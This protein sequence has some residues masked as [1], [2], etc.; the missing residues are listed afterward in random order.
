MKGIAWKLVLTIILVLIALYYLYPTIR[1]ATLPEKVRKENPALVDSLQLKGLRL[2][3]DL[4]GGTHLVY[5]VD[6]TKLPPDMAEIPIDE[7]LEVIR[8]RVDQFGVAEPVIQKAGETRIIVELPGIQDIERAKQLIQETALLEFRLM[9]DANDVKRFVD[10]MDRLLEEH[11]EY[12]EMAKAGKI[13]EKAEAETTEI[14]ET[15]KAVAESLLAKAEKGTTEVAAHIESTKTAKKETTVITGK[16]I[17]GKEAEKAEEKPTPAPEEEVP[18]EERPFSSMVFVKNNDIMVIASYVNVVDNLLKLPEVKK[19]IPHSTLLWD[20]H[21]SDYEG[22]RVKKLYLLRDKAELTG[23][24]L[25]SA[26][27]RLG[28][29]RTPNAPVVYLNF[30]AQGTK[31]FARVTGANIKKRLAI[32]LNGK[33]YTAPVINDRIPSGRAIIEGIRNVDEAKIITIVLRAGSLP[34]PLNIIEERSVGPLLGEDSIRK[35]KNAAIIGLILVMIFMIVYYKFAGIVA[36]IA[37]IL[38]LIL[39]LGALAMLNATLTLPGIAGIILTIGMAVDAN[40][41]IYERIREELRTGKTI[42]MAIEAGYNRVIVTIIDANVTTLIAALVL[43][44]F[45]T[46]PIKGF[47]IT[48]MLGLLISMYTAI[49][50]TRMIFDWYVV[51]LKKETISI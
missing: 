10:A 45:G 7:A 6:T 9:R 4:K 46:G 14:A 5:E 34:V 48:L 50:V 23:A 29:G 31:I 41:L 43:F 3:L 49:V 39:L 19:L 18:A 25:K 13:G 20:A 44:N 36:D 17:F 12:L 28:G 32:V 24:H 2:G 1:L 27:W 8:T 40:V 37:L 15:T 22:T 42:R 21:F 38:N 11:P 16:A 26:S 30:D 35:G 51:G 47:A 33:V